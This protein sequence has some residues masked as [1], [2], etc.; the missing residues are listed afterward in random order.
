MNRIILSFSLG[1][2][3]A[4]QASADILVVAGNEVRRHADTGT[5][6]GTFA[7]GMSTPI[8]V[9][10]AGTTGHVFVGQ[11]GNGEIRKF[12]ADGR[13]MGVV[14]VG[15]PDWQPAGLA[16]SGGRL[17]AASVRHKALAS[18]A[19]DAG[20]E[21][22]NA[23]TPAPQQVLADLPVA[24][25]GIAAAEPNQLP[26]VYFTTSNDETGEGSL[27]Y[28]DGAAGTREKVICT[29]GKGAKPRGVVAS[30]GN[31]FVALLGAGKVVKVSAAGV[32]EDWMSPLNQFSSPQYVGENTPVGLVAHDGKL[33]VSAYGLRDQGGRKVFSYRLANKAPQETITSMSPPQYIAF[34]P[35]VPEDRTGDSGFLSL[36]GNGA[37]GTP[38][39]R[40]TAD[41][42][43]A[44]LPFLSWDSEGSCGRLRI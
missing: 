40:A 10:H 33:Y 6:L 24:P 16:I 28:W 29:F 37:V 38:V 2:A 25:H 26:G 34:V 15:Q 12:T 21:D 27:S 44:T 4:S 5:F 22:G 18:Y 32:I 20:A 17:Y 9:A 30:G 23:N 19:P 11:F 3:I 42:K 31:V 13:D 39:L 35:P 43:S 1:L 8:G 14:L 36:G 41:L 7:S